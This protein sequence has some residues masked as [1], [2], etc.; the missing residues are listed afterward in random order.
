MTKKDVMTTK[1]DQELSKLLTETR[2][3]LRTERFS[4]AG[5]RAKDSNAPRKLSTII[6]RIL[7]EQHARV[8]KAENVTA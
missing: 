6:A 2:A 1:T 3:T 5:A 7:T 8:L 4:A